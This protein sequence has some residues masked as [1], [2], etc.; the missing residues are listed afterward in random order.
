MN[1][2]HTPWEGMQLDSCKHLKW[3]IL[4]LQVIA[5]R[6]IMKQRKA[7]S[8]MTGNLVWKPIGANDM[9]LSRPFP[10]FSHL[11]GDSSTCSISIID[12]FEG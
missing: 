12:L 4:V 1:E 7:L 9:A 5:S 2:P 6:G 11:N 10:Q 8:T 3:S